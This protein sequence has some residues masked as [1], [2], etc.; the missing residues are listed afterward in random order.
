M[1][2]Q[3]SKELSGGAVAE[4]GLPQHAFMLPNVTFGHFGR[5]QERLLLPRSSSGWAT[6]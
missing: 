5:F 4:F 3:Q 2:G 1:N 6:G